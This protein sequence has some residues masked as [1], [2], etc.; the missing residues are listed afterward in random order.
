VKII[1]DQDEIFLVDNCRNYISVYSN[2]KLT[3]II[4]INNKY[5]SSLTY[6]KNT[7]ILYMMDA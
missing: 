1:V 6:K 4:K 7:Y 2:G 3:K 5:I